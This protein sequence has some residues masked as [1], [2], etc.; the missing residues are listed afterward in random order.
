MS[1]KGKG[2]KAILEGINYSIEVIKNIESGDPFSQEE[3]EG[4][5][6]S[7]VGMSSDNNSYFTPDVICNLIV[8]MLDIK[9]GKVADL[10]AGVGSMVKPFIKSYSSLL[11]GIKFDCYEYDSNNSSAGQMA[12]SDYEQVNY[13]GN[14]DSIERHD[15][16]PYGYDYVIGN[17]PFSGSVKYWSEWNHNKNGSAKNNNI[18]DAFVDLAIS[19]TKDKGYIALVLP[20]G[21]LYKSKATEK[22]REWMMKELALKAII[23][24]NV[25]TFKDAGVKGTSVST[26]LIVL[27]KGVQQEGIFYGKLYDKEDLAAEIKSLGRAFRVFNSHNYEVTYASDSNSGLCGYMTEKLAPWTE[28]VSV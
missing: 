22:L 7:Y 21:H 20:G 28:E 23:P 17:P 2:N 1:K 25:D 18:C 27:Q 19:K 3:K 14:F 15:E 24:L 16:I 12:W 5:L 9:S 8:D 4:I 26:Y 10:S 11:D 6:T 13:T